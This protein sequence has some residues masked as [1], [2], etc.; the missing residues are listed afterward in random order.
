MKLMSIKLLVLS[1]ALMLLMTACGGGMSESDIDATV[2]ARAKAMVEA[3][4]EAAPTA[5]PVPPIVTRPAA[6]TPPAAPAAPAPS[7]GS[8]SAPAAAAPAMPTPTQVPPTATPT[9]TSTIW[10]VFTDDS[11]S[12]SVSVPSNWEVEKDADSLSLLNPTIGVAALFFAVDESTGYN[13]MVLGDFRE[14]FEQEPQLIDI[15]QYVESQMDDL[16]ESVGKATTINKTGVVVDSI[17]ATQLRMNKSDLLLIMNILIS[18]EPRM[19]CGSMPFIVVGVSSSEDISILE[20]ALDSFTV[21]PT[22]AIGVDCAD[23]TSLSLDPAPKTDFPETIPAAILVNEFLDDAARA[24]E[25]Y[26]LQTLTVD[27]L[28]YLID[29]DLAGNMYVSVSEYD[30]FIELN[31]VW[32]MISDPK[33]VEDLR[34]GNRVTVKGVFSEFDLFDVVLDPCSIIE[35]HEAITPTP[36]QTSTPTPTPTS[37]PTPTPTSV[38]T[39]IP[40]SAPAVTNGRIAFSSD[41]DGNAE[42]YVMNVDGSGQTNLTNN[43]ANDGSPAWSPE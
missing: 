42:I 37:I 27:G 43:S 18:N 12:F 40:T 29:Y 41:R 21:L 22:A 39:P 32:C 35:V 10:N 14:L 25:K 31:T 16:Q 30:E 34:E 17:E 8:S 11:D 19:L 3:T 20:K 33:E 38:P 28:V 1:T 15:N 24:S 26:Y 36:I 23:R 7:G 13:V 6:P 5:K 4:A 2:K 9:P